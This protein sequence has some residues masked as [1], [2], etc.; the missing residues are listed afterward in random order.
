MDMKLKTE[1]LNKLADNLIN[2]ETKK[3]KIADKNSIDWP[4]PQYE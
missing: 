3:K 1:Q 4:I 2:V